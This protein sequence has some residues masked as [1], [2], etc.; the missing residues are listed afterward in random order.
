MLAYD[1]NESLRS[2]DTR[3]STDSRVCLLSSRLL[4]STPARVDSG[5]SGDAAMCCCR[6]ADIEGILDHQARITTPMTAQRVELTPAQHR[7]MQV[8]QVMSAVTRM[9]ALRFTD[10]DYPS[11]C[12]RRASDLEGFMARLDRLAVDK[13]AEVQRYS[14]VPLDMVLP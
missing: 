14:P 6:E 8:A 9:G 3:T 13:L 4:P 7:D 12:E 1:D 5:I 10:Q 2:M 11:S